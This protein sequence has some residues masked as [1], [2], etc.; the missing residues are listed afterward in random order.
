MLNNKNYYYKV[1]N[2]SFKFEKKNDI[3]YLF[4]KISFL[5]LFLPTIY[6]YKQSKSDIHFIYL[7]KPIFTSILRHIINY[8][9]VAI[10]FYFFRIRLRGLG[11]K[12]KK[13]A[14]KLYR[15]FFAYNHYFYF[16]VP[17]DVFIKRRRRTLIFFCNNKIKLNDIFS[18][19]LLLKKIDLYE[20]NNTFI[21]SRQIKFFKKR[22]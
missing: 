10:K 3:L 18:H 17:L 5:K 11:Y 12:I 6:F 19:L 16:H 1:N 15:F 4:N 20:R 13:Y 7:N 8:F 22:K 21:V 2:T 9:N 14:T